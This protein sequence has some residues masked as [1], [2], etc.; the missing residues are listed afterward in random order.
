[1][2]M[3]RDWPE[4]QNELRRELNELG[5]TVHVETMQDKDVEGD[6][7]Y[8]TK[9]LYSYAYKVLD[10]DFSKIE[11]VHLQ[12][13]KQEWID[14]LEG[15][16]NPGMAWRERREVWEEFL[17]ADKGAGSSKY[18]T[19]FSYTYS[20]RMGGKHLQFIIDEL[21]TH[22][23]SRQLFLPVWDRLTDEK[24][25]GTRRVP[26]SLGYIFLQRD[27]KV[28]MTYLM[29][30]CDLITHFANDVCLASMTQQYVADECGYERGSFCHFINSLHCYRKDVKG[31]F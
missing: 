27:G 22:P 24:R 3:F 10:P 8:T 14:R 19:K 23:H 9:E 29:R 17:E 5:T 26:C 4:C 13:L 6:E 2:R 28:H 15:G 25:R 7:D 12:W 16:L 18:P 21:K 1:M 31:V 11:G 20:D 30:S